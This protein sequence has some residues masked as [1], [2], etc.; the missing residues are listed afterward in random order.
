[1]SVCLF[2]CLSAP[3]FSETA[4]QIELEFYMGLAMIKHREV[5]KMVYVTCVIMHTVA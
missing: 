3:F 2:V 1:M 5:K 4:D